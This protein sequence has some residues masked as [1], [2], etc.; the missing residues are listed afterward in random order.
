MHILWILHIIAIP[1]FVHEESPKNRS[2]SLCYLYH[3][4]FLYPFKDLSGSESEAFV[5]SVPVLSSPVYHLSLNVDSANRNIF[6]RSEFFSEPLYLNTFIF[7]KCLSFIYAFIWFVLL[8][9]YTYF[10]P[11][12]CVW[13][14]CLLFLEWTWLPP[15][16][17]ELAYWNSC[18]ADLFCTPKSLFTWVKIWQNVFSLLMVCFV[19]KHCVPLNFRS[20]VME[21]QTT[22][23]SAIIQT[24]QNFAIFKWFYVHIYIS[25]EY[26]IHFACYR[27]SCFF[28]QY[29]SFQLIS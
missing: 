2:D 22:Y 27:V 24:R 14:K 20:A 10:L 21:W 8:F 16:L 25:I 23:D 15:N 28:I 5:F 3:Q 26:A 1:Q 9:I 29:F 19:S 12:Q 6:Y 4:R 11:R 18:F 17:K 13:R 7:F